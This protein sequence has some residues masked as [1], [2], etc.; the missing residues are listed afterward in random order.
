MVTV[1]KDYERLY[2][3]SWQYNASLIISELAKIVENHGGKVQPRKHAVISNRSIDEKI[4]ELEE[5][6]HKYRRLIKIFPEYAA[7]FATAINTVQAEI[8]E[9]KKIDNS[10]VIVTHTSYIIFVLDDTYYSYAVKDNPYFEFYYTKTPVQNNRYSKDTYLTED[11]KEWL[12]GCFFDYNCSKADIKEGA[13]LIFNMLMNA[14]YSGI[15]REYTRQRV[16]NIYDG[17]YHYEKI[18]IPERFGKIDF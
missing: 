12:Y 18:K 1:T 11:K 16:D 3:S 9:L 7:K 2:L 8:A 10:P 6:I 5:H 14:S 15:R 17:G 4:R 13:N